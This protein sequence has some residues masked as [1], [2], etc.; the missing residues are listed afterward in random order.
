MGNNSGAKWYVDWCEP[1]VVALYERDAAAICQRV[2]DAHATL[3]AGTLGAK[4][5]ACLKSQLAYLE[6]Q[7]CAVLRQTGWSD[8]LLEHVSKLAKPCD[9]ESAEG[10]RIR[11]YIQARTSLDRYG[12]LGLDPAEFRTLIDSMP[13]REETTEFWHYVSGWAFLH[14]EA[15]FLARAYEF[16]VMQARGFNVEWTWHRVNVMWRMIS[17]NAERSD[18]AWLLE[19]VD[20]PQQLKSIKRDIWPRAKSLGLIDSELEERLREFEYE[21]MAHPQE[22]MHSALMPHLGRQARELLNSA[23]GSAV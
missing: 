3:D 8:G 11:L 17:G 6:F 23:A 22:G 5:A 20:L 4:S 2:D 14:E 18:I 16:A 9:V 19:K 10:L 13:A 21:L 15:D 12:L 7:S 1:I